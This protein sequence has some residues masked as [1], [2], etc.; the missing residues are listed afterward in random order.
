ML[1]CMKDVTRILQRIEQGQ[2]Q[3]TKELFPLVYAELRRIA[4][5]KMKP[6]RANHTL[7]ATALV[8]EAY[9]QLVDTESVSRW[10][11]RGHFFVAAAEAMR[12]ILIESARRKNA[13]KRGGDRER[14]ELDEAMLEDVHSAD[15]SVIIALEEAVSDLE[16]EDAQAAEL[17]K[18]LLYAGLSVTEAGKMMGVSSATAHRNWAFIRLW[19]KAHWAIPAT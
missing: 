17:L 14:L 16:T 10:D 8:H 4:G 9:I 15:P 19:F 2:A 7:S 13:L 5:A 6:E 12:R 3:G 18:L 1:A 11:S